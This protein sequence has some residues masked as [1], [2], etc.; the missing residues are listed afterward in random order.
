MK[1]LI[2]IS[3]AVALSALAGHS[4][5]RSALD[6]KDYTLELKEDGYLSLD[7]DIDLSD[8]DIKTTQVVVLTPC[9][10]QWRGHIDPQVCRSIWKKPKDLLHEERGLEADR[11]QGYQPIG[12]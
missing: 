8:L 5:N 12:F 2:I 11:S 7:I 3:L 6:I 9:D 1:R 10:Y 4:Q